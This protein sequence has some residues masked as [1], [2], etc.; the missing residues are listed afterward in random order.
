MHYFIL[1]ANDFTLEFLEK[2]KVLLYKEDKLITKKRVVFNLF[3]D[4]EN[5]VISCSNI[6]NT[7]I[8]IK[9]MRIYNTFE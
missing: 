5:N 2:G 3:Y 4:L 8:F 7:F 6:S 9:F 1:G